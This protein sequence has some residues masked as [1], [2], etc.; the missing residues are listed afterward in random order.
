[1]L[2]IWAGQIDGPITYFWMVQ[3]H[4]VKV[5]IWTVEFC[6]NRQYTYVFVYL[7]ASKTLAHVR[8]IGRYRDVKV[9]KNKNING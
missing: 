3:I 8:P 9:N 6:P 1:M 4:G 7:D 2:S 5:S